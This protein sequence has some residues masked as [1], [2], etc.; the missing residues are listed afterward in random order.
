[1]K[2]KTSGVALI[3]KKRRVGYYRVRESQI[4]EIGRFAS[5]RM[6]LKLLKKYETAK[7]KAK[8]VV[9]PKIKSSYEKAK[10]QVVSGVK[11]LQPQL[12]KAKKEMMRKLR[13][14]MESKE[15]SEVRNDEDATAIE[16]SE[17]VCRREN[18][19]GSEES[20]RFALTS[21]ES[22]ERG[23]GENLGGEVIDDVRKRGVFAPYATKSY[24]MFSAHV[25]CKR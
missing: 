2:E 4:A 7:V 8:K 21:F 15:E 14:Y 6:S 25:S 10:K 11:K 13:V 1:M 17:E 19:K 12:K 9:M 24:A 18:A 22:G 3:A 5:K 20:M 16:E 23:F